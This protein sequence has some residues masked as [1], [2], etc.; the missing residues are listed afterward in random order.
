MASSP[1]SS[2]LEDTVD[3]YALRVKNGGS[4]ALDKPLFDEAMALL[5]GSDHGAVHQIGNVMVGIRSSG[6]PN[7][8]EI[9]F[10]SPSAKIY[11]V[12]EPECKR[13][14]NGLEYKLNLTSVRLTGL[15]TGTYFELF[16]TVHTPNL[17]ALPDC[18]EPK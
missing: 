5:N 18:A 7:V 14:D 1:E 17:A 12:A 10:L 8:P 15:S 4:Q 11:L 13:P 2:S 3:L 6:V 16:G 9:G